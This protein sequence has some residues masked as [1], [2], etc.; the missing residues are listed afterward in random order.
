M[1]NRLCKKIESI[2]THITKLNKKIE[3]QSE[4]KNRESIMVLGKIKPVQD[5]QKGKINHF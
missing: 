5:S 2:E 3:K 4:E 1:I